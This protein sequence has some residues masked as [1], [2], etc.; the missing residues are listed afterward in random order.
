MKKN[1]NRSLLLFLHSLLTVTQAQTASTAKEPGINVNY[2]D[3]AVKPSNNFF[4][5]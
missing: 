1:S 4:D 5:M 3:K 2:M